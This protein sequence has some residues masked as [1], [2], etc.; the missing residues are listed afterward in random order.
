MNIKKLGSLLLVC[1]MV[2]AL[3]LTGCN[4][5]TDTPADGTTTTSSTTAANGG[6]ATG[7]GAGD[8]TE[9]TGDATGDTTGNVAG[10]TTTSAGGNTPASSASNTSA[11]KG[12]TAT[13]KEPL[14]PSFIRNDDGTCTDRKT[15]VVFIDDDCN[16]KVETGED[17]KRVNNG[18]KL[19]DAS[20]IA[21]DRSNKEFFGGDDGRYIRANGTAGVSWW[22]SYKLDAGIS[23]VAIQSFT[24]SNVSQTSIINGFKVYVSKNGRSGWTEV[25][26]K[27]NAAADS[28]IGSG[29][30]LRTYTATGI[31]SGSKY[32]KVEFDPVGVGDP[33]YTPNI[34]RVRINNIDKMNEADRFLEGR[35]SQTFYVD[36]KKGNDNN[37][38]TSEAK[39][40]KS[41]EKVNSRYY[42]PGD[43]IL[44]KSGDTFDGTLDIKGYGTAKDRLTIGTYGG[45][46]K[47]KINARGA[48]EKS[49][50]VA[51][52]YFT[53]ENLE[54]TGPGA[55]T[56]LQIGTAHGGANKGIIVQNC[57][58]H[59][60]NTNDKEFAYSNAGINL[61]ATG[62]EPTW[63]D[64]AVVRNNVVENVA[65]VGIYLT[66]AWGDR[67]GASWGASGDLY[68]NDNDGWWPNA[69]CSIS[70]NTILDAHGDAIL[71]IGAKDVTIE[72]NFV[73]NAF[74]VPVSKFNYIE[75][76]GW[77]IASAAVWVANTN[78]AVM[79]YN[80][81]G[82]THL[83]GAFADGEAFDIDG[84]NKE[85]YV[86]YNY[87]HDNMG[88]FLLM[89]EFEEALKYTASSFHHIRF[90]LSVNDAT[91]AG[92]GVFMAT[93]SKA[94]MY[95]YNNT[96]VKTT[97][98]SNA[99]N[100]F[101]DIENYLFQNN[102]FYGAGCYNLQL[103]ANCT[104]VK[105]DN[106][107]FTGGT[108]VAS[109]GATVSGVK[110]DNPNFKNAAFT[111]PKQET[112]KM[113]DAL[114]AFVPQTK[115]SG[116]TN[117][118]N[119]GGKDINGTKITDTN[120]YGC[121]KY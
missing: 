102:I 48:V 17:G 107:V 51:A 50:T 22:F 100:V 70:G 55:L 90:N 105:F 32:L 83:E 43:S 110:S 36:N 45:T 28:S 119:N 77:N 114:K 63:F 75:E 74:C 98:G 20:S 66:G 58:V 39:A 41:L 16:L 53:L 103:N 26:L 27:Y 117:V 79:Q 47:A 8:A 88:G 116:A 49:V 19:Y 111:N 14:L 18:T 99:I 60:I 69:N 67:P 95:I 93:A 29:W 62:T 82:Y 9:S 92:Q 35:V 68:K 115:I 89:C 87:S 61:N 108:P 109:K 84:A 78:N 38:G 46:K 80:D 97:T 21:V 33:F 42:Q 6:D 65:R 71:V 2:F 25:S 4:D 96:I 91:K 11:T 31:K 118:K 59:D 40:W 56:G 30:L 52:D 106:N 85:T 34:A 1:A 10:D 76:K 86:Q 3:L 23:E 121:I 54:I 113:A 15:R 44:F 120:F 12:T 101:G 24:H 104:N 57:Y 7:D 64:G 73:N 72:K 112:S 37:D 5:N 81:V 94:Q 13:K